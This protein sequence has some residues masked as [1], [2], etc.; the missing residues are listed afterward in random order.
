MAGC[1]RQPDGRD[2]SIESATGASG[3]GMNQDK[4]HRCGACSGTG[5]ESRAQR[6]IGGGPAYVKALVSVSSS[7][8]QWKCGGRSV[9]GQLR[10]L[11]A[12]CR[13]LCRGRGSWLLRPRFLPSAGC[14]VFCLSR[15]HRPLPLLPPP[16]IT[17]LFFVFTVFSAVLGVF[18][19]SS[20]SLPRLRLCYYH[21]TS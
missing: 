6:P 1:N 5:C 7:L 10:E 19:N 15:H 20:V 8:V 16:P 14:S 17:T 2:G 11:L 18:L 13:E 12:C 4:R 9:G 3:V 21:C